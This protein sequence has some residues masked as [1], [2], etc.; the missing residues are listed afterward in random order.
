[1]LA[2]DGTRPGDARPR[3]R[4][5]WPPVAC[6]ARR[7]MLVAPGSALVPSG[8]SP[9]PYVV[10][11]RAPG[12]TGDE[13]RPPAASGQSTVLALVCP[14][15]LPPRSARPLLDVSRLLVPAGF[16]RLAQVHPASVSLCGRTD[17]CR[18][19]EHGDQAAGAVGATPR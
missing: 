8:P 10:Y 5:H 14:F 2:G 17:R 9:R 16:G 7:G 12:A 13:A 19:R 1:M 18:V 3:A 15:G 6:A 4:H 11:S